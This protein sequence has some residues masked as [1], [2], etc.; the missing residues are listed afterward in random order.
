MPAQERPLLI[1]TRADSARA[2]EAP[3][4]A[5]H[6]KKT[7][8]DRASAALAAAAV[9]AAD[10]LRLVRRG[11]AARHRPGR[12]D[13]GHR[14][15]ARRDAGPAPPAAGRSPWSPT[16][17]SS[18]TTNMLADFE[19]SSGLTV[20]VLAQGDAGAM[21][22]QLLLTAEQPA[23]RRGVRHRQHLRL[24]GPGRRHPGARTPRRRPATG[25]STFAHRRRP[26]DRGR[27][28]RR[29]RQRRPRLLRREGAGR[30]G[31]PSRTWPSPSTRTCWSSSHRPRPHRVW[32]SCWAPSR[33]SARTAGRRTGPS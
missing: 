2:G 1:D 28:R 32:R 25:R 31:R 20:T 19:A 14:R 16:T 12:A 8:I 18:S 22:N 9:A 21:V 5:K 27:L 6:D 30:T 7:R 33:T 10:R 13:H 23:G 11:G 4:H 3:D 26:A 24:Q 17:R 29:L 15:S